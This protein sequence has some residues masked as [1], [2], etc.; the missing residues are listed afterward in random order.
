MYYL[1]QEQNIN[2]FAC[3]IWK[4]ATLPTVMDRLITS[5]ANNNN[6]EFSIDFAFILIIFLL[7]LKKLEKCNV[8]DKNNNFS[9]YVSEYNALVNLL[10]LTQRYRLKY[11]FY[12]LKNNFL[13]WFVFINIKEIRT[14]R[15]NT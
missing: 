6:I 11:I 5:W 1:E 9:V 10:L 4:I 2:S 12:Q 15:E 3:H 13:L 7:C 8:S 14:V